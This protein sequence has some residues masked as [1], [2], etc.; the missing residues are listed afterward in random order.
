MRFQRCTNPE[1]RRPFQVNEFNGRSI[2]TAESIVCPHCAHT[3]TFW[4]DSI[5]LVHALSP[6]EEARFDAENPD[7]R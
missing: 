6:E 1:C 4:T 2:G 5:F 7:Q 3:E